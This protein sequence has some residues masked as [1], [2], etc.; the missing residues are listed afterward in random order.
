MPEDKLR[1]PKHFVPDAMRWLGGLPSKAWKGLTSGRNSENESGGEY[2]AVDPTDDEDS[3]SAS[4]A[5]DLKVIE[6]HY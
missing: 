5:E 3:E 2:D 4:I 1:S 6:S